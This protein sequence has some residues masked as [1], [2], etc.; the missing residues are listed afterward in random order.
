M[1]RLLLTRGDVD[2]NIIITSLQ[3]FYTLYPLFAI[4]TS[5][6]KDTSN[7]YMRI[8]LI[9]IWLYNVVFYYIFN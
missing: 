1:G 7:F 9:H 2:D 8:T 5:K 3:S 4:V 6:M